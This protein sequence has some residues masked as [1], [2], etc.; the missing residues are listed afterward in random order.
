MI[1]EHNSLK[2]LLNVLDATG[3]LVRWSLPLQQYEFEIIHRPGKEH[4][5][6]SGSSGRPYESSHDLNSLRKEDP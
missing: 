4:R 3:R 2:W 1:A 5:N 6:N